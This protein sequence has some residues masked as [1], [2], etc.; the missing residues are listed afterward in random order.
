M[1][2][3]PCSLR[4]A[5]CHEVPRLVPLWFDSKE[6]PFYSVLENKSFNY[7]FADKQALMLF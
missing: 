5:L 2:P 1:K 3:L 6:V 4:H 7:K